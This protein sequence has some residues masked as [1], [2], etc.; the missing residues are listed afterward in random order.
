MERGAG[1]SHVGSLRAENRLYDDKTAALEETRT[2][3]FERFPVYVQH[4]KRKFFRRERLSFVIC[5]RADTSTEKRI[6]CIVGTN[7]Q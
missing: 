4:L 6:L 2:S 3:A 7:L 5:P 1:F